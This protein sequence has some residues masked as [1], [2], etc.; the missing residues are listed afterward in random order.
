MY[1]KKTNQPAAFNSKSY[2]VNLATL[3]DHCL[4]KKK[5]GTRRTRRKNSRKTRGTEFQAVTLV[6][7][8]FSCRA[9]AKMRIISTQDKRTKRK[10]ERQKR[11]CEKERRKKENRG[12]K[13]KI[14][15]LHD[16]TVV[17]HVLRGGECQAMLTKRGSC[18]A[19]S[20]ATGISSWRDQ[21]EGTRHHRSLTNNAR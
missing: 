7:K 18:P 20:P 4:K 2:P 14:P 9:H 19:C 10:K 6:D 17:E 11:E 12:K 5:K 3:S 15:R 8:Q 1:S 21:L 13:D 16:L